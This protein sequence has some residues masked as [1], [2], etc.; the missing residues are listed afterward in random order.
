MFPGEWRNC[1]DATLPATQVDGTPPL[2]NNRFQLSARGP[3]PLCPSIA[4]ARQLSNVLRTK[5]VL[6][7]D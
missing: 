3:E 1:N 6:D 4:L 2:S 7:S 5:G